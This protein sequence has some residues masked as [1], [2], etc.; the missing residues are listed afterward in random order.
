MKKDSLNKLSFKVDTEKCTKC[1]LC[2]DECVFNAI[3]LD[4]NNYPTMN[5]PN[6]CLKCQHCSALCPKEAISLFDEDVKGPVSVSDFSANYHYMKNLVLT[7]RSIRKYKDQNVE[8]EVIRDL[9]KTALYAPTGKN[10]CSIH[11]TVINDKEILERFKKSL[12]EKLLNDDFSKKPNLKMF[13]VIAKTYKN[14]GKDIV[15]AGAPHIIVASASPKESIDVNTDSVIALSYFEMLAISK[16]LGTL[17]D[18]ILKFLLNDIYPELK[19]ELG[20]PESHKIGYAMAFGIPA[21]T[22]K[23]TIN[24]DS[25][26]I[27]FVK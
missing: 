1:G 21:I 17:W 27:H 11:F 24:R 18:G 23:N 12:Y 20:I 26:N 9:C 3:V 6:S 25:A 16:G 15:F 19:D 22:Y 4:E 8:K 7:R 13:D 14:K 10:T 2:A 5:Y